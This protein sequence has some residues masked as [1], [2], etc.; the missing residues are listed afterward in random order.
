MKYRF[1]YSEEKNLI[2]KETRGVNFE[3]VIDAI[4]KGDLIDDLKHP[5]RR[6]FPNQRILV[7]KIKGYIYLA[8]YVEDKKKGMVFLK[9]VYPSRKLSKSYLRKG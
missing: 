2:L 9:T 5:S 4:E 8:P 1:D 6:K 3:D 7:V